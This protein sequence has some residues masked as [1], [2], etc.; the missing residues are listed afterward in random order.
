VNAI[1]QRVFLGEQGRRQ[2][3]RLLQ[4]PVLGLGDAEEVTGRRLVE[5]GGRP[6]AL[7]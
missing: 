3:P 5:D 6:R 7:L 1:D 2:R 4:E